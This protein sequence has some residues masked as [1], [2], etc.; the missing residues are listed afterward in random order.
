M[1]A[2]HVIILA[3]GQQKRLASLPVA[4]CMLKLPAC[5]E[6]EIIKRTLRQ[7]WYLLEMQH[8]GGLDPADSPVR[9]HHR[10]CVV[11]WPQVSEHLLRFGSVIDIGRERAITFYPHTE[12]L[13]EPG[14]SSLKGIDRYLRRF[15]EQPYRPAFERTVVLFGDVVYSWACLRMI[16]EGTHWHCGFVG[17]RDL[18]QA[19]GEL[20]GL[21]WEPTAEQVMLQ[22]LLAALGR[23][24]PF[25]EYQPGQMRRWLWEIGRCIDGSLANTVADGE[26]ARAI[27]A[28]TGA[29]PTWYRAC[30]DYTRDIDLPE[31]VEMLQLLSECARLDDDQNGVTW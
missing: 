24:P 22:A 1:E 29:K 20:W 3:Q 18:S 21:S 28:P 17:T 8:N 13:T 26:Y 7:L 31:H 4:K 25:A 19:A 2:T 14:N 6:I 12:T 16:L 9:H 15:H 27:G 10:I 30:D 5:R 11:T 23:H